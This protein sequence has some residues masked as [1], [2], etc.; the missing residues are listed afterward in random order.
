MGFIGPCQLQPISI[1][2]STSAAAAFHNV[3]NVIK[4]KYPRFH[5]RAQQEGRCAASNTICQLMCTWCIQ[6]RSN[7]ARDNSCLFQLQPLYYGKNPVCLTKS[8]GTLLRPAVQRVFL[9]K[10][11]FALEQ[12][13][14]TLTQHSKEDGG[15]RQWHGDMCRQSSSKTKANPYFY[16]CKQLW[17]LQKVSLG[18]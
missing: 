8:T 1:S 4:C 10:L 5:R 13:L 7:A 11:W 15:H 17:H 2:Q 14:A 12:V 9:E 6:L 3:R 16:W 18:A